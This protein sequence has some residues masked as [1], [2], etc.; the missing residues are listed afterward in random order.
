ML[1]SASK[2]NAHT[3]YAIIAILAVGGT[4]T[5]MPAFAEYVLPPACPDCEGDTRAQAAKAASKEVPITVSTDKSVYNHKSM[6]MVE[7]KVAN[8]K[9]GVPVTL[10]VTSPSNNIVSIQQLNVDTDGTFSTT[11]NT[12]GALWKYDGTYKIRVQ[13]GSQ[14]A[15]NKV[16]VELTDGV[17]S[18]PTTTPTPV[19]CGASELSAGGS[20][21]PYSIKGGTVTGA[22]VNTDDNSIVVNISSMKDG[23]FT[24]KATTEQLRGIFMVLV[25]GEESND[26]TFGKNNEVTVMFPAGTE[27][28]EV[29]GT[30]VVPEF[31][32]IAVLI[33]AVAI[34]SI[35]AVSSR[36][37]LSVMPKF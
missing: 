11:L 9:A 32:T 7:G 6:I 37:K 33:L 10:T 34:V 21:I 27:Q 36:S 28:I 2:M 25:D 23:E 19:S 16:L 3:S 1:L 20:C 12:A 15:N 35:I 18:K 5:L 22:S 14:E 17:K 30:F 4:M 26:V 13:Y 31:G 24:L 29:I 8:L